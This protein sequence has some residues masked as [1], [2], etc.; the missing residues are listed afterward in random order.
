MVTT[1]INLSQYLQLKFRRR[2]DQSWDVFY[3]KK[4][5]WEVGSQDGRMAFNEKPLSLNDQPDSFV[6]RRLTQDDTIEK[7][8]IHN[9]HRWAQIEAV[10]TKILFCKLTK[11]NVIAGL[12]M[13]K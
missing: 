4:K 3:L 9:E 10:K 5:T 8:I 2:Q 12:E 13:V 7:K 11:I 1:T 6:S